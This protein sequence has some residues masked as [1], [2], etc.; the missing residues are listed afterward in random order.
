MSTYGETSQYE[1]ERTT[2]RERDEREHLGEDE[3]RYQARAENDREGFVEEAYYDIY[4]AV[5]AGFRAG[6]K[7]RDISRAI[8]EALKK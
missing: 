3:G 5:R 2:D 1:Q 4:H 6:L 8:H 7:M